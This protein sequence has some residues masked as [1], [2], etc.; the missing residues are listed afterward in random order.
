M[1]YQWC[2]VITKVAGRLEQ[3]EI[4]IVQP[5]LPWRELELRLELHQPWLRFHQLHLKPGLGLWLQL[6]Q[7]DPALGEGPKF[8]SPTTEGEFCQV[9]PDCDPVHLGHTPYHVRRDPLEGLTSPDYV[10]LLAITL[11]VGFR[12]AASSQDRPTLHLNHTS[13]WLDVRDRILKSR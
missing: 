9:G 5:R 1:A 11:E 12:L 7:Q 8:L 2:S 6:R 13:S 3:R 10:H 4:H